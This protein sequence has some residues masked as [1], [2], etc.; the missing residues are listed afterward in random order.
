M[1]KARDSDLE[2]QM[3]ATRVH[4]ATTACLFLV[5][6]LVM[7]V[8]IVGGVYLYQQCARKPVSTKHQSP[9]APC[10]TVSAGRKV[11]QNIFAFQMQRL[12]GFLNVPYNS[13]DGRQLYYHFDS[14]A[15]RQ[16]GSPEVCF[17]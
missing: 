7:S 15:S 11:S 5:G 12:R 14:H 9:F 6:L 13:T 2:R 1:V 10:L 4:S 17:P 16:V 8:G 3:Q